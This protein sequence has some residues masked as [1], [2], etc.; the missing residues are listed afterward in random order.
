MKPIQ[1]LKGKTAVVTGGAGFVP[2][3]LIDRLL[4]DGLRVV[5]LDNFVTGH[6]RNIEHLE[7]H[8][9][10]EFIEHIPFLET[11]NYVK[12]VVAYNRIY[13]DLY[14]PAKSSFSWL[15]EPVGVEVSGPAPTRENWDT[16]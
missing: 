14:A 3:H 4:A 12:K 9:A 8:P 2:S 10:F 5:A 16:L 6:T 13:S 15:S 1:D 11:R 7:S